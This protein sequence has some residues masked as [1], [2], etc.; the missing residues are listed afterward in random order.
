MLFDK[1]EEF[2]SVCEIN[3]EDI[4]IEQGRHNSLLVVVGYMPTSLS[5]F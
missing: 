3:N 2:T 5:L 4:I 1:E